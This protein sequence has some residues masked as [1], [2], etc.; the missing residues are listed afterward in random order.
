[1]VLGFYPG[2]GPSEHRYG[3]AAAFDQARVAFEAAW[4]EYPPK[5]T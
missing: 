3:T 1:M 5:R 4:R 2:A